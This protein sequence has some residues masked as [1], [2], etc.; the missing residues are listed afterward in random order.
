VAAEI[1][2]VAEFKAKTTAFAISSFYAGISG[3]L[4]ASM[5]GQMNPEAWNLL[6]SVEFVAILLIGGMGRVSGA[7]MG[8]FFVVLSPRFVEEVIKWTAHQAEGD[9]LFSGFWNLMISLRSGDF[10][11]ISVSEQA[12][13]FPLPASALDEIIYGVLIIVF[14]LFEPLGLFGIWVKVRNYWKGWPFSY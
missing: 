10:G 14:L 5:V 12:L 6:L 13:G 2:G 8:T 9:G 4:L 11:F 3:A 1:M 7:I